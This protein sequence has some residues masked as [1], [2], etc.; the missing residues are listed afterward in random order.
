MAFLIT[1]RRKK[2]LKLTAVTVSAVSIF[3]GVTALHA[4]DTTGSAGG[5]D[6]SIYLQEIATYTNGILTAVTSTSNPVVQALVAA[7]TNLTSADNATDPAT[8]TPN[9]QNAFTSYVTATAASATAL[10]NL[11]TNLNQDFLGSGVTT[12]SVPYANDLTFSTL[13]GQPFFTPDPRANGSTPVNPGY[14]YLKNLAGAG[15]THTIPLSTWKGNL[16]DQIKY[17]AYYNSVS[18]IQTFNNYIVAQMYA[19]LNAGIPAIQTSLVNQASDPKN[20]FATITNETIGAVLRQTL[21]YQSQSYIVLTQLLQTEKL[22]LAAQAANTTML[23]L[24]S[25]TNESILVRKAITPT[26]IGM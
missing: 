23:L 1:R 10:T 3:F 26:P 16:A 2:I 22:L 15:F 24:S 6:I 21:M 19:D 4:D 12:T 5:S 13:L 8:P 20:W 18:A 17:G 9:L 25:T 11:Q 14:N 7:L